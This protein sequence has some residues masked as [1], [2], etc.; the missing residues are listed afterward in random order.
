M[1]EELFTTPGRLADRLAPSNINQVLATV[2][3]SAEFRDVNEPRV[4]RE[5]LRTITDV[6]PRPLAFLDLLVPG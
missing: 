3:E 5:K 2:R 1:G 6:L 4:L